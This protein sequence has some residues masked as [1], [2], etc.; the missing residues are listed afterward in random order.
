MNE[1]I[2]EQSLLRSMIGL[3][4]GSVVFVRDYLQIVFDGSTLNL[5]TWPSIEVDNKKY[6]EN[7]PGYRDALCKLIDKTITKAVEHQKEQLIIYF[8]G[9][10][11]MEVSL[12]DEDRRAVEAVMYYRD[13]RLLKVW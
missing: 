6:I 4:V 10:A 1:S 13:G 9:D 12:K 3:E 2:H 11:L 5:V 8:S 7:T